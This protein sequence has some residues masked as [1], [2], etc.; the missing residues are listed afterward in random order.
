M[1]KNI[2]PYIPISNYPL[3][4]CRVYSKYSSKLPKNNII[5]NSGDIEGIKNIISMGII[6]SYETILTVALNGNKNDIKELL[7]MKKNN[8]DIIFELSDK[9]FNCA[10]ASGNIELI[11]YL[12]D[13][14]C[15]ENE[16][17]IMEVIGNNHKKETIIWCFK[18]LKNININDKYRQLNILSSAVGTG[19]LDLVKY[20]INNGYMNKLPKKQIKNPTLGES[21]P[22]SAT[23]ELPLILFKP[24]LEYLI[25][26]KLS[27]CMTN[28]H[29][30]YNEEYSEKYNLVK[31]LCI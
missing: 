6:P 9:L 26:K 11:K 29:I 31:K 1:N 4:Y 2:K 15:E 14:E 5:A 30:P 28:M 25:S 21:S 27:Y 13:I 24:M 7:N 10:C 8:G 22:I 18:N 17:S 12:Q 23:C 16:Y 19:N 3:K 20:L